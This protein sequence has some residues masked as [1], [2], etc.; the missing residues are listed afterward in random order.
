[1]EPQ[2]SYGDAVCPSPDCYFIYARQ[3]SEVAPMW[4]GAMR[5]LREHFKKSRQKAR[6]QAKARKKAT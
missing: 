2:I 3:P 6:A 4:N 5:A 1:M